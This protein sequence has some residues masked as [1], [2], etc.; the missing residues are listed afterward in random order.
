MLSALAYNVKKYHEFHSGKMLCR[1]DSRMPCS[2]T[3]K[4]APRRIDGEPPEE[5]GRDR[6]ERDLEGPHGEREP[7]RR[8][9]ER[10]RDPQTA[11]EGERSGGEEEGPSGLHLALERPGRVCRLIR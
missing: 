6:G 11:R 10:E 5:A 8:D 2:V 1:T 3:T 9:P 7:E 4:S